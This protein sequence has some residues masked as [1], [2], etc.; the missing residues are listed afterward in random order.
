MEEGFIEQRGTQLVGQDA[1]A[2]F[3]QRVPSFGHLGQLFTK[4]WKS[5]ACGESPAL[6]GV[7]PI[8]VDF[9]H[10]THTGSALPVA[11]STGD[12]RGS[13]IRKAVCV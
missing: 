9:Q 5:G 11:P 3:R 4:M 2:L 8:I 7:L 12:V 6:G 1:L 13:C 10:V